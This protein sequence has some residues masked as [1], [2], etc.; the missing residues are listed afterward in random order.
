MPNIRFEA[1]MYK[2]GDWNI[3][4]LPKEE[5]AKL[6]SRGLALAEGT[7]NGCQFKT[8][9]E[10]DGK[11]SHWFNVADAL[12]KAAGL[13]VGK[14]AVIELG[15]S[16]AWPEPGIPEDIRQAINNNPQAQNLWTEITPMARWDWLRWIRSTKNPE[17]RAHRIDIACDKL[18]NGERRP[19]CFNRNIC[20]VTEVSKNGALIGPE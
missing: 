10:P 5:S 9:L 8:V 4:R 16:K 7:I 12:L 18:N 19:C 2:T 17:T 20:T 11:G 13:V 6:P 15:P 3:I 1:A 14:P